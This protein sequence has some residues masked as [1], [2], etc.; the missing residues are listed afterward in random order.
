MARK[1]A[2]T[3]TFE[4]FI[5]LFDGV[6]DAKSAADFAKLDKL[7]ARRLPERRWAS[8]SGDELCYA[9]VYFTAKADKTKSPAD[10]VRAKRCFTVA[11]EQLT[12][13]NRNRARLELATLQLEHGTT[14]EKQNA[15]EI[16]MSLTNDV[17]LGIH[18][19]FFLSLPHAGISHR[20]WARGIAVAEQALANWK[21]EV[22]DLQQ[23]V[24]EGKSMLRTDIKMR[25]KRAAKKRKTK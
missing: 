23:A 4:Y 18:A 7:L 8:A 12:E 3:L 9:G 16:L 19:A 24:R 20:Q 10:I 11:S 1:V 21:D 25:K 17:P 13:M 2:R 15:R 5:R 6:L 22:R 14:A